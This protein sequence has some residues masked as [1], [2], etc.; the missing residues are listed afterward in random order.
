MNDQEQVFSLANLEWHSILRDIRRYAWMIV[1]AMVT[2]AMGAYV[3]LH[4]II[5]PTFTSSATIV[6]TAKTNSDSA[7]SDLRM[8][9]AM[10]SVFTQVL[11]SDLLQ[12]K[13]AEDMG[14]LEFPGKLKV[15]VI[16]ETNLL[17]ISTTAHS[18]QGAFDLMQSVIKVYPTI[19]DYI[20]SNAMLDVISH[21]TMPEEATNFIEDSIVV[22]LSILGGLLL[23]T[24]LIALMS[25]L[26]DT[27][28][29]ETA[30]HNK[31]DAKLMA[32]I[33]HENKYVSVRSFLG[34]K[35]KSSILLNNTL[36]SFSF[37]ETFHK[38]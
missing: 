35:N 28:K 15:E 10:T 23:M 11:G 7:Y 34:K 27:V 24:M 12:E 20:Y 26:K 2:A 22:E 29:T 4:L 14:V 16:P 17:E 38:I 25:F 13:V 21:P 32:V 19:S 36:V 6:V 33:H 30:F 18:P 37:V 9:S 1:M 3:A 31:V 5:Q 8:S